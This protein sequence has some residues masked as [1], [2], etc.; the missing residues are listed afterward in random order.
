MTDL[1]AMSIRDLMRNLYENVED[2]R[3]RAEIRARFG[4]YNGVNDIVDLILADHFG[5]SRSPVEKDGG[6]EPVVSLKNENYLNA[7]RH[8]LAM[9]Y[10][11]EGMRDPED[12]YEKVRAAIEIEDNWDDLIPQAQSFYGAFRQKFVQWKNRR[13]G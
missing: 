1:R 13:N 6:D 12:A 3:L 7:Y 9:G 5:R 4:K 2:D 11:C 8:A 10:R